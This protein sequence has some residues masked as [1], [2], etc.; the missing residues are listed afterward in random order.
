VSEKIG[1]LKMPAPDGKMR[2]TD[3]DDTETVK[4]VYDRHKYDKQKKSA[5]GKWTD[6]LGKLLA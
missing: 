5:L 6:H 2:L 1:Q 4:K 3:C